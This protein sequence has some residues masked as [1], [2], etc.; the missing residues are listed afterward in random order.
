MSF[1]AGPCTICSNPATQLTPG[2]WHYRK[3]KHIP[4][5]ATLNDQNTEAFRVINK[6]P[7]FITSLSRKNRVAFGLPIMGYTTGVVRRPASLWLAKKAL[8]GGLHPDPGLSLAMDALNTVLWQYVCLNA[9]LCGGEIS[10]ELMSWW[11]RGLCA[12]SE[13]SHLLRRHTAPDDVDRS[14]HIVPL[15]LMIHHNKRNSS[16]ATPHYRPIIGSFPL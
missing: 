1:L 7:S 15:R 4:A 2:R 8:P 13:G 12:Y 11:L 14:L 10:A 3:R 6:G 9:Y 16:T 5:I